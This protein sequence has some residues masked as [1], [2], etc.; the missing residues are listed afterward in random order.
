[1]Y[2]S[3]LKKGERTSYTFPKG[4]FG[5]IHV[6]DTKGVVAINDVVLRGGDGAFI[7]GEFSVEIEGHAE[8]S[9]F[10]FFD[11]N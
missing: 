6:A 8:Q 3:I 10:V 2:A 5:Y 1:M 11:L 7:S 4:R 9:E